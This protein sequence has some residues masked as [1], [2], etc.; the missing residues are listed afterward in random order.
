MIVY[1]PLDLPKIEPDNWDIF[2]NIWNRHAGDIVKVASN[3][4]HSDSAVGRKDIWRGLD[5]IAIRG[6]KSIWT[7]PFYDISQELPKLYTALKELPIPGIQRIRLVSSLQQIFPH[8]DDN[9]D[10][11]VARAYFHYTAPEEQWFFTRP[12]D[13]SGA[14][15]YITRPKETNWFSYN[16]KHCWHATDYSKEYP[17]ILLQVYSQSVPQELINASIT[18][19]KDYTIT[20]N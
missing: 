9:K 8:S 15:S 16:D 4:S 7:A 19:Y 14:K 20:Y 12:G 3:G 2:W 5:I 13:F 17:K 10:T 18:K 6:Y 11:W 1:T